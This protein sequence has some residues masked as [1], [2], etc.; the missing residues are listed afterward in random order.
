MFKRNEVF[1]SLDHTMMLLV[2]E[3]RGR[4]VTQVYGLH[5]LGLWYAVKHCISSMSDLAITCVADMNMRRIVR[6]SN[7][8]EM[9]MK[10]LRK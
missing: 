6:P 2:M 3:F 1:D 9:L 7:Y 8:E 4:R 5:T 10:L